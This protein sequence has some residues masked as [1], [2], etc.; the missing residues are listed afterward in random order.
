[1][2][3][4][5]LKL[6]FR[7]AKDISGGVNREKRSSELSSFA[8]I[9][10]KFKQKKPTAHEWQALALRIIKDLG[11]PPNKKSSVF[12]V[13]KMNSIIFIERCLN[14]TK[15]LCDGG[16]QWQYFFK[17]VTN[18]KKD[19]SLDSGESVEERELKGEI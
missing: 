4:N 9:A 1:M 18:A 19:D 16:S 13:C 14:D 12:R 7:T 2:Q 11:V 17:V 8:D 6:K 15:E 3:D 10:S 5:N